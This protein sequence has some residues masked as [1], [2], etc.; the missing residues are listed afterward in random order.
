[1]KK[2]NC[3]QVLSACSDGS[4]TAFKHAHNTV[5]FAVSGKEKSVKI[6]P[7]WPKDSKPM[8]A[9]EFRMV[10]H[11]HEFVAVDSKTSDESKSKGKE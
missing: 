10:H 3:E 7:S 5:E 1:M 4:C 8:S 2:M 9:D 6:T 11:T